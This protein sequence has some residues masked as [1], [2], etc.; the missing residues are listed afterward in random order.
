LCDND[1]SGTGLKMVKLADDH[2]V[3]P[4]AYP[5]FNSFEPMLAKDYLRELLC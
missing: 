2:R 1:E 3:C 5:D 4:E